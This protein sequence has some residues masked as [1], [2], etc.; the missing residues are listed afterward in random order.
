MDEACDAAG[1]PRMDAATREKVRA[2]DKEGEAL[3][4][5]QKALEK[6]GGPE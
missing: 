6:V 1:A 4:R 5:G 2:L 3:E